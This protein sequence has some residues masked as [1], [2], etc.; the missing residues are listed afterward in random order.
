MDVWREVRTLA[1]SGFQT[2]KP[3]TR[4]GVF[5]GCIRMD[6]QLRTSDT[7][8][9]SNGARGAAIIGLFAAATACTHTYEKMLNRI[10]NTKRPSRTI[11]STD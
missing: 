9:L 1:P 5:G 7:D 6:E 2:A 10:G 4:P 11:L 3:V 8:I